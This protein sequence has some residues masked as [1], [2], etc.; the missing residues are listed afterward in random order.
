[1]LLDSQK[2]GDV[3][4]INDWFNWKNWIKE[5]EFSRWES[6]S[7]GFP[8]EIQGVFKRLKVIFVVKLISDDFAL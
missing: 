5:F 2:L 4:T 3:N 6:N 8:Q 1:M 7:R